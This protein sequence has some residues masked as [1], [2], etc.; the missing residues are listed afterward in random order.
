MR[1]PACHHYILIPASQVSE[2]GPSIWQGCPRVCWKTK[3]S[4]PVVRT[5]ASDFRFQEYFGM[6]SIIRN[7]AAHACRRPIRMSLL[8]Q[9]EMTLPR[10]FREVPGVTV[11]L[12]SDKELARLEVLRDLDQQRLTLVA[13]AQLLGLERRQVFRLLKVYRA[14]GA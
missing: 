12:M 9:I 11:R 1:R 2:T 10:I 7:Y 13:A 5:S 4:E 14:E 3:T 6:L 8:C